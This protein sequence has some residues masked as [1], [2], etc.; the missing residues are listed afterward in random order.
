MSD[1]LGLSGRP[2]LVVGAGGLGGATA[3]SL[4]GQGACV[5]VVDRDEENL[6]LVARAVKEAGA[7]VVTLVADV[8]FF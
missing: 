6:G 8:S 2:A 7:E 4:A 1:W 5:V 3:V